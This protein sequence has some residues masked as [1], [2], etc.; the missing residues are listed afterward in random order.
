MLRIRQDHRKEKV[1]GNS[2]K[3]HTSCPGALQHLE[4]SQRRNQEADGEASGSGQTP[5][6]P[7]P[8]ERGW[9]M[10]PRQL[11]VKEW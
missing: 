4:F 10:S 6:H 1:D 2:Q 3:V 11:R 5:P 8:R 9:W 7:L